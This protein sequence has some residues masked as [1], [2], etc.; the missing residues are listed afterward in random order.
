MTPL[1][2]Q[3]FKIFTTRKNLTALF[4]PIIRGFKNTHFLL[5]H[6]T[7][8]PITTSIKTGSQIQ[9]ARKMILRYLFLGTNCVFMYWIF[10]FCK[11][12]IFFLP[13]YNLCN[14][15]HRDNNILHNASYKSLQ[16]GTTL[17]FLPFRNISSKFMLAFA[18]YNSHGIIYL[19]Y[20]L[21]ISFDQ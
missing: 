10:G 19:V 2:I 16:T 5:L 11:M 4:T 20:Y 3:E 8:A 14:H 13:P 15:K 9:R 1:M 21:T 7:L 6:A 12:L 17:Y 18:F